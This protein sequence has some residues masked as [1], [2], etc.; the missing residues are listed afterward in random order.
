M[1]DSTPPRPPSTPDAFEFPAPDPSDAS[2]VPPPPTA[3]FLPTGLFAQSLATSFPAR[4]VA[5][6]TPLAAP[7][8]ANKGRLPRTRLSSAS[9][10]P[11]G[12]LLSAT[13]EEDPA[14][15]RYNVKLLLQPSKNGWLE[16]RRSASELFKAILEIDAHARLHPWKEAPASAHRRQPKPITDPSKIHH[17][18]DFIVYFHTRGG[19]SRDTR[20]P[21]HWS[22]NLELHVDEKK[23]MTDLKWSLGLQKHALYRCVLQVPD[24]EVIGWLLY[25]TRQMNAATLAAEFT[26]IA[27]VP[28]GVRWRIIYTGRKPS[29]PDPSSPKVEPVR[30][31]HVETATADVPHVKALLRAMYSRSPDS[32]SCPDPVL[33]IRFRLIPE[34]RSMPSSKGVEKVTRMYTRQEAFCNHIKEVRTTHLT[35]I[36][37]FCDKLRSSLRS[38]LM[39]LPSM[40]HPNQR[41]FHAIEERHWANDGSFAFLV[42]P[43]LEAEAKP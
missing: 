43:Q 20:G 40:T 12:A 4:S 23:F 42:L 34:L 7:P 17:Y 27:G 36:D 30:A 38:I 26:R 37:F 19:A 41:L 2:P 3:R 22:I 6:R 16:A 9:S 25:S 13:M 1:V 18:S 5:S 29:P 32:P 14:T 28:V 24:S 35:G 8:Q 21:S 31:M 10:S 33:G 39:Q 15:V 11:S